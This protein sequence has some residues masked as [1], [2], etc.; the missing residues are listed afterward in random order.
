MGSLGALCQNGEI[1]RSK[2]KRLDL[3]FH[4]VFIEDPD[5]DILAEAGRQHGDPKIDRAFLD[6]KAK[7][8][9]LG[10][11]VFGDI[12][13]R[14]HLDPGHHRLLERFGW[15][16][17]FL[18]NAIDAVTDP[19]PRFHG[20]NQQIRGP[21]VDGVGQESVG[22]AHDG[23]FLRQA[24]QLIG[25]R[26]LP[27]LYL[28]HL[29]GGRAGFLDDFLQGV[30]YVTAVIGLDRILEIMRGGQEQVDLQVGRRRQGVQ[31]EHV[32]RIRHRHRQRAAHAGDGHHLML[33]SDL[34]RDDALQGRVH[35]DA[36][37]A[38]GGDPQSLAQRREERDL[39]DIAALNEDGLEAAA[40]GLLNVQGLLELLP[41]EEPVGDQDVRDPFFEA[42]HPGLILPWASRP[43]GRQRVG[44]WRHAGSNARWL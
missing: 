43:L 31:G 34:R 39:V 42:R 12:Q 20:L 36:A 35:L 8:A 17:A 30:I 3:E 25:V 13:L 19:K 40:R 21:Q 2:P 7:V 37:Q 4:L 29:E 5:D 24:E 38:D 26:F 32:Q 28:D 1:L 15:R 44:N 41:R 10:K 27:G 11:P 6:L 33:S 14:H 23:K 9:V 22:Q 16:L 18:E